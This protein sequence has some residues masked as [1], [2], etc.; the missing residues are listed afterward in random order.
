MEKRAL[1]F[2]LPKSA[3]LTLLLSSNVLAGAASTSTSTS[4]P[5]KTGSLPA[6]S[7]GGTG[8]SKEGGPQAG[9]LP[10]DV[11]P[12]HQRI[13]LH[14]DP[15]RESY[16]GVVVIDVELAQPRRTLWLHARG[17][18]VQSA[19]VLSCY[20]E[21]TATFAIVDDVD[22]VASLTV[23][24]VL[25]AGS[26]TLTLAFTAKFHDD[27]DAIYRVKAGDDWYV[28]TQFE[29]LAAREAFP[30]FDEPG[31]KI[32]FDVQIAHPDDVKAI[33]NTDLTPESKRPHPQLAG[34]PNH[35][36]WVTNFNTTKP[37]PTY[38]LA[39]VVGPVDVVD[40]AVLPP[41]LD[42]AAPLALR[43]IAVKGKGALLAQSLKN[44]GAVIALQEK[45][46]GIGYPYDKLDIVAV[47]DFSAGAME[48]AGLVTY[49][50]TLLFVDDKSPIG[51]QKSSL[52]VIAHELAHQWFG[53]LV[54]MA[55]WDDLWLNEAF[56]TWFA[57][58]TVQVL[59]PD[60]DGNLDLR[61]TAS[62]AMSEDT[63]V[64]ARQIREPILSRGD[65]NNAFD[66]I[67][68][69]KGAGVIAM[70]EEYIDRAKGKGTFMKGVS[71][72]LGGHRFGSGTTPDF[73]ASI[74]AAATIDIAPA[75]STFLDQPGVPL[76]QASCA[77]DGK[78][79][80]LP[81]MTFSAQRFLPVGSTGDRNKKWDIPV[82]VSFQDKKAQVQ[83]ALLKDGAG[84]LS[85]PGKQC[86]KAVHPNADGA[87]Y[88]RFAM[89]G[90]QL[91]ALS[92]TLGSMSSGERL[93]LAQALRAGFSSAMVSFK[94]TLD[95]ATPLANDVESSIAFTPLSFL[96]FAKDE[97]L[98][99]PADT[100]ARAA[101]DQRVVGLY[102]P[103]LSK[104]GLVD[105]KK[106]TPRDKE[107]R[108]ALFGA[109]VDAEG[110]PLSIAIAA[111]KELFQT[112][113]TQKLANDLWPAALGAAVE[114][115]K[116]D[117]TV[118]NAWLKT[119]KAQPDPRL[120]RWMLGALCSTK[121][122]ALSKKALELVFDTDLRVNEA[123][124]GLWGQADDHAT[125]EG[126]F[127][128]VTSRW[129]EVIKR[130]P[131]DWR[132][133]LASSFSGFCSEEGAKKVEAFFAPKVA[134]TPGLQRALA[135]T[136]EENRLCAARKAAHAEGVR[137]LFPN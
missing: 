128:F 77:L 58:R 47:P 24:G 120:R 40:G 99:A 25:P 9:R 54:T 81:V 1:P 113:T 106:D 44:A 20:K 92:T 46:F 63:L 117:A 93:S 32:P 19:K 95:A 2:F 127:V 28:F 109:V 23:P 29:P 88:Y 130:L 17:I 6:S 112:G 3:L 8:P 52:S 83:C 96:D 125:L 11:T 132:P 37:L 105:R 78:S 69:S 21:Q 59:R 14:I 45:M 10:V 122:P 68:Y 62:S 114:H 31:F 35:E 36:T 94:D 131:E 137:A 111:G 56:A 135:Q 15:K 60:F 118:W 97:V 30:C 74:S 133:G 129:D 39:W 48:N 13:E 65:I 86:P 89:P 50:D 16:S 72:Y 102:Q 55:W 75:F 126:A 61:E 12:K 73:L 121:D 108:A 110:P 41:S 67:T 22:G 115:G 38:L 64:S 49:R 119:T 91:K 27:L 71:A 53:N 76:V 43:G 70:F 42:R 134:A 107:T 80:A 4:L 84:T 98:Q 124:A 101:V 136:L 18:E 79:K 90:P 51:A 87:G 85:L 104:L 7:A 123:A 5:A 57:A 116:I 26:A 103:Q 34:A 33:A 66:G 100:K 82:C